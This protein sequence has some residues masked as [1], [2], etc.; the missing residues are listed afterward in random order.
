[1]AISTILFATFLV[2]AGAWVPEMES[3]YYSISSLL[4]NRLRIRLHHNVKFISKFSWPTSV[5]GCSHSIHFHTLLDRR[6]GVG[7]AKIKEV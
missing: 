7:G 5:R 4:Q 6:R 3:K 1:M 2:S